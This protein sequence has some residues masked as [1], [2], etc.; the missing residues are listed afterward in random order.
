MTDGEPYENVAGLGRNRRVWPVVVAAALFVL[1]ATILIVRE[2]RA[3]RPLRVLIAVDLDGQWWEGSKAAAIVSDRI[4]AH[5]LK[6]G[7]EPV[8]GGDPEAMRVLERAKSPEEAARS[9]HAAFVVTGSMPPA[10]L[11]HQLAKGAYYEA[12]AEGSIVVRH[13]DRLPIPAGDVAS[14]G[15][16]RDRERAL[17]LLADA[18]AQQTLDV[19]LPALIAD[20]SIKEMLADRQSNIGPQVYPARDFVLARDK[21]MKD[22]RDAWQQ[23][24]AGRLALENGP[25]KPEYLSPPGAHDELAA[26]VPGGVLVATNGLRPWYSVDARSLGWFTDL[27]TLERRAPGAPATTLFRGY[28]LY[29]YPHAAA[30]GAPAVLVEDLFGWAKTITVIEAPG[31][32][33]RVRVDPEHRFVDPRMTSDGKRVAVYDR[34]CAT[35]A[36]SLLVLATD[37]GRTL[38]EI[39]REGGAFEGLTWLDPTHLLFLHT[40]SDNADPAHTLIIE[41]GKQGVYVADVGATPPVIGKGR[42]VPAG[43]SWA[44]PAARAK[45]DLVAF[46]RRDGALSI[47]I[48]NPADGS[49]VMRETGG[50]ARSPSFSPDGERIVFELAGEI[51]VMDAAAGAP[52]KLT[53]NPFRDRYPLFSADGTHVFYETIDEDPVYGDRRNLSYIAMVAAPR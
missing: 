17:A 18:I 30:S 26:I 13:I 49:V 25:S 14:F 48:F 20:P 51:A 16:A 32:S 37:D 38:L 7:F 23:K 34:P 53:S 47:A 12:R 5:L 19:V 31:K 3:P 41:G 4:G 6:L 50:V 2:V 9:L 33:R 40:A 27:E 28:N 1:G 24:L 10:V 36:A 15:G 21:A 39:D 52:K 46:E 29:G 45:G 43:E 11:E 22:A 8:R 42:A 35:C 44:M